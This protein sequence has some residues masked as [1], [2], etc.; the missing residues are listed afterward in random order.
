MIETTVRF[1]V[2]SDLE[3]CV[4]LDQP[5]VPEDVIVAKIEREEI[6]LAERSGELA[7]YVRLE[8][9]W[10]M[11]PYLG[12][13]WVVEGHRRKGVGRALLRYLEG[14]LRQ[15]EHAALY[16]S[17]Q[18]DEPEPQAWHRHVGFGECGFIAGINDG[19]I[20]EVF[21]RKRLKRE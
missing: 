16:S 20:G 19:G 2:P 8:Y 5:H 10:S 6:L 7:G 9:L 13:I 4:A 12:L 11:I 15:K 1:A 3:A 14:F 21:F 18:A 17:S